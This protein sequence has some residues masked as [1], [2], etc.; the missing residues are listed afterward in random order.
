[1][2]G[3]DATAL[4]TGKAI[5]ANLGTAAYTGTGAIEITANSAST[6]TLLSVSGTSLGANNGTGAKISIGTSSG[7]DPTVGKGVHVALGTAGTAYYANAATGYTGNLIDLRV[8]AASVFSVNQAGAVTATGLTVNGASAFNGNVTISAN[9]NF[10]QNGTGTFGTGSG[11]V[12]INGPLTFTQAALQGGVLVSNASGSVAAVAPGTSGNVLT[13]NGTTFVSQ[14]PAAG[15][16]SVLSL[17]SDVTNT[18]ATGADTGLTKTLAAGTYVFQYVIRYQSAATTTG[19]MFGVNFTGTKTAFMATA[20]LPT[21]GT[22]AVTALHDQA[23]T[24]TPTIM[25]TVA[26][27]TVSSTTPNLG[28]WTDVDTANADMMVTI[29]GLIIVTVSGDLQLWHASE[30]AASSTVKAGT[31]LILT[32]TG[33]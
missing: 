14:A 3:I 2:L 9:N 16:T 18:T 27:R 10:I 6:G 33:P 8:N 22:T 29:D 20:A 26:T 7:T 31:S 5:S 15:A 12:T 23:T 32:K 21:T 19:V 13:S 28:P 11:L 25:G 24:T 30:V 17:S 4:T 1:V